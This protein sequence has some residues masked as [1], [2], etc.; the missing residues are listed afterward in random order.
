MIRPYEAE[1]AKT[2]LPPSRGERIPPTLTLPLEGEGEGGGD[3][4]G[5]AGERKA[6]AFG[7]RGR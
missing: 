5:E 4:S 3:L 1:E 6:F 7:R 2:F